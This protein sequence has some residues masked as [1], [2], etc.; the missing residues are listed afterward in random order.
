MLGERGMLPLLKLKIR[1]LVV[2][3]SS[4]IPELQCCNANPLIKKE[5]LVPFR[6][7]VCIIH[8]LTTPGKQPGMTVL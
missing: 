1:A 2:S 5:Q 7:E 6:E 4:L 3:G 8:M